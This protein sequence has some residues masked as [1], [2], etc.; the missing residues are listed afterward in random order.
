MLYTARW[1][2]HPEERLEFDLLF[3]GFVGCGFD[4]GLFG[5]A[6]FSEYGNRLFYYRHRAGV[7]E[8]LV[9]ATKGPKTAYHPELFVRLHD[10]GT[11]GFDQE[12][13]F[14]GRLWGATFASPQLGARL[15]V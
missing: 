15:Q 1:E 10:F 5:A 12:F 6:M 8:R 13:L 7:S 9:R 2:P 3:R 4:D 14:Q 11:L